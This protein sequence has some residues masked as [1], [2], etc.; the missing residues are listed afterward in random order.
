MLKRFVKPLASLFVLGET[1]DDVIK[2]AKEL[3]AKGFKVT[4]SPLVEHSKSSAQV[5]LAMYEYECLIRK[6]A[7][8]KIDANIAIKLSAFMPGCLTLYVDEY[9]LYSVFDLAKKHGIFV[10]IDM[11]GPASVSETLQIYKTFSKEYDVGIALQ[12]SMKRTLND[13]AE[14]PEES[15]VRLCKGAYRGPRSIMYKSKQKIFYNF[16]D[17]FK[18]A[19]S[20]LNFTVATHD[21]SII[22]I[23]ATDGDME[24][25]PINL[26]DI[27]QEI[28]V[29]FQFLYG[30]NPEKATELRDEGRRVLIYLPYGSNSH[31]YCLRRFKENPRRVISLLLKVIH[32]KI[33]KVPK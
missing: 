4:I 32:S 3:N 20:R 16:L 30:V 7:E 31:Y 22:D 33:K 17:C 25:Y 2:R 11:E 28:G 14:L 8:E 1:I 24:F 10:W 29:E 5:I 12:T 13:I 18:L 23:V 15:I 26:D 21:D 27:P 9:C 6:V 19:H